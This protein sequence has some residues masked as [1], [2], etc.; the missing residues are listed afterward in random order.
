MK[1]ILVL[2]ILVQSFVLKAQAQFPLSGDLLTLPDA[3][4]LTI[5]NNK[6]LKIQR[7]LVEISENNLFRGNSGQM[8]T[9]G[10]AADGKFGQNQANI[11]IRT[12]QENPP[13]VT[14]EA[15]GVQ[16]TTLSAGVRADYL[17]FGGFQ[18]KYSYQILEEEQT[19]ARFEQEALLNEL[20]FAVSGLYYDIA[21]LQSREELLMENVEI[22]KEQLR[23]I[24]N[25]IEF[26]QV[27]GA[28]AL[29]AQTDINQELN[30]LDDVLVLKNNLMKELNFLMGIEPETEYLVTY[31]FQ[32]PPL[33]ENSELKAMV[34]EQNPQLKI[35]ESLVSVSNN[36]LKL[37]ESAKYPQLNAFADYGYYRQENDA[38]QLAKLETLGYSA[39]FSLNFLIFDG[40]RVNRGIKNAKIAIENYQT[41]ATLLADE[42]IK[43]AVKEQGQLLIL[44][45][46]L[47][48]QEND[49]VTFT[50]NFTRTQDRFD[51]GLASSLDLREAQRSLLNAKIGINDAK[52][53]IL[54]SQAKI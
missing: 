50:D 23:R 18:G 16:S 17:L 26:G 34:I 51:R 53:D 15:D 9:I 22:S 14:I 13:L 41:Q 5:A 46:K 11:D 31:D 24:E 40:A 21:K 6:Q 45:S 7:N 25:Q 32:D 48:R 47:I 39:G 44:K 43:E 2:V 12:F 49:L 35:N 54:K 8:P 27:T 19:I 3:I 1:K 30:A 4:D 52:L 29:A 10:F 42:L 20:I 28:L 38:Q 33:M 37:S 36:Q